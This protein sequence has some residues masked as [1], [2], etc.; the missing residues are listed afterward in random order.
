MNTYN[1]TEIV[2]H[3]KSLWFAGYIS[4]ITKEAAFYYIFTLDVSKNLVV[5][6]LIYPGPNIYAQTPKEHPEPLEMSFESIIT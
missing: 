5:L 3:F 4:R 1:I 2:L 6:I